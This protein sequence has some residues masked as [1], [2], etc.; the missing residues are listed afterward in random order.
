MQN[1]GPEIFT[2][3][4]LDWPNC[5]AQGH[6]EEEAITAARMALQTCVTQSKV[7]TI[8]IDEAKTVGSIPQWQEEFGRFR[9]DPT[10]DD[11]LQ[12]IIAARQAE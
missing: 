4:I 1:P 3:T 5:V 11:F 6:T 9:D 8:E 12:E 10:F 2:A 7:V